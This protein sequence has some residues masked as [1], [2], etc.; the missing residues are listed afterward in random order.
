MKESHTEEKQLDVALYLKRIGYTGPTDVSVATLTQL[1]ERHLHA[2]PYENF[3]ILKGIPL[4]LEI[5]DLFKKIVD[6]HRGG[7]CFEL[8]ACLA[9]SCGSSDLP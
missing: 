2:V 5:P 8:N 4:S 1:Q 9:G 3:D 7:Y 6:Q